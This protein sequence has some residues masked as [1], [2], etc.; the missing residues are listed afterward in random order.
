MWL[1]RSRC[2]FPVT[3]KLGITGTAFRSTSFQPG[4]SCPLHKGDIYFTISLFYSCPASESRYDSVLYLLWACIRDIKASVSK[5]RRILLQASNANI[6][7]EIFML[8]GVPSTDFINKCCTEIA[9]VSLVKPRVS[10]PKRRNDLPSIPVGHVRGKCRASSIFTVIL[11]VQILV[12]KG[13][14]KIHP[15]LALQPSRSMCFGTDHSLY[16]T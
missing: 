13:W 10:S 3:C 14:A 11:P 8:F 15:A 1:A 12:C 4:T 9:R 5:H 7:F 16:W 6:S 2:Y